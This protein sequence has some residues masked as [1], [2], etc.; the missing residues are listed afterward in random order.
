MNNDPKLPSQSHKS[1]QCDIN[2]SRAGKKRAPIGAMSARVMRPPQSKSQIIPEDPKGQEE[3]PEDPE[4][5][6]S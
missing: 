3:L 6:S 4:D 2:M 5:H 1:M